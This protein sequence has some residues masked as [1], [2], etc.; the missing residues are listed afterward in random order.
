MNDKEGPYTRVESR[1]DGPYDQKYVTKLLQ[2]FRSHPAILE[3]PNQLFY[4]FEL[5]PSAPKEEIEK[6]CGWQV[7]IALLTQENLPIIVNMLH[8]CCMPC[9]MAYY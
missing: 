5:I 3:V 9:H 4:K 7:I 8:L 2:N 6:F 1:P